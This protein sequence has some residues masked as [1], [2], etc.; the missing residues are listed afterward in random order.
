MCRRCWRA[1]AFT[2][3]VAIAFVLAGCSG[4]EEWLRQPL[5]GFVTLDGRPLSSG[6][7]AIYP[8]KAEPSGIVLNAGA[9]VMGGYFLIPR[10]VGTDTRH[11]HRLDP[12]RRLRPQTST[13]RY[14]AQP[15]ARSCEKRRFR[16]NIMPRRTSGS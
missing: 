3:C 14:S 5:A 9:D 2:T 12:C 11:L 8:A 7:I 16:R 6:V 1:G 13:G 10:D 4:D 15:T